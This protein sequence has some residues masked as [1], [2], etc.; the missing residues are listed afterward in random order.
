M[1]ID[2]E[3]EPE[4]DYEKIKYKNKIYLLDNDTRNIFD[5]DDTMKPLKKVGKLNKKGK[6]KFKKNI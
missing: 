6:I 4:I 5:T 2:S 3:E 1:F